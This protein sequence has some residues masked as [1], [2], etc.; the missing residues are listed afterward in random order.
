MVEEV[1]V[2]LCSVKGTKLKI[3]C[4][5]TIWLVQPYVE[6]RHHVLTML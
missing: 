4:K 6:D 5:I 1:F 2:P 3:D